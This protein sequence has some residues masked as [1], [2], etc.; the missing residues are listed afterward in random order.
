MNLLQDIIDDIQKYTETISQ[1]TNIDVEIMGKDLVR[2]AG[3]GLL[4]DK[5]GI[6]MSKEAHVYK[7]V[8]K[9]GETKII[10]SPRN[11]NICIDCPSREICT[12]K[13]ELSSPI[14]Y[15]NSVI[16]VIGLICF[17]DKQKN[18]FLLKEESYIKF[19][20][21]ISEFISSKVLEVNQKKEMEY[22]NKILS[23]IIDRMPDSIVLVDD[24]DKIELINNT[25]KD[26]LQIKDNNSVITINDVSNI[27]DKKEFSL[28]F[29]NNTHLVVGDIIKF[30]KNLGK[31][32]TLYVF[33]ETN[34]FI[35]YLHTFNNNFSKEFIF[36]SHEMNLVYSKV[37]KVAQSNTTVL[38][39]GE[40][41]VG[42]EVIAKAIH[43]NSPRAN[44]PFIAVNCGA[45]PENLIESEFFGYVKGAFT[46]ANP[47][48]KIGYF[49]Q[50]N[51]GTIFLDE[52]GDMPLNLQVKI[53]RVLQEKTISPIGSDSVK[54]IDIR[55][56]AAT[57]KNLEQ[58]VE[59]EKFREDLYYRLNV[60][61]IFIA[62]LRERTKDI[63]DLA[64]FFTKKY[65]DS[66]KIKEKEISQDVIN[67]FMKYTWPGNI[68]ELKNII[69]YVITILDNYEDIILPKHLPP[70]ML[71]TVD[72]IS[73]KTLAEI[74]KEAINSLLLKY[75]TSSKS[76]EEIAKIL[77]IG[78][79]TLYRKIKLYNL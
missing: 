76:K 34:K 10:T 49:E 29:E 12:E 4:R 52:I 42:K 60:F 37:G 17:S 7:M 2:V 27:L 35:D 15:K 11:Q 61:P 51:K 64:L 78:I 39:T 21:Q 26:F 5:I 38:I 30:P 71:T 48:G 53:L 57:N 18:E 46:G 50:A 33:Q 59:A 1:V 67:I 16:G 9:T 22:N 3:T 14:I 8:L 31:S 62:P 19:I 41:G 55:I 63:K 25:G 69:E 23:N 24:D 70:K 54:D 44:E 20:K 45:I 13:L 65:C 40:S 56:V 28:T 79:A 47:K 77:D 6:N 36:S 74:E 66:F 75:G 58:L 73:T 32:K 68:R 43:M 72:T